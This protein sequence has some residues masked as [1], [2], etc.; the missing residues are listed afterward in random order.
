MS[1]NCDI[2]GILT[3]LDVYTNGACKECARQKGK[4]RYKANKEKIKANVVKWK[5]LN[6]EHVRELKKKYAVLNKEKIKQNQADNYKKN[7]PR[8]KARISEYREKHGERLK[9]IQ[10]ANWAINK[11]EN[12]VKSKE[13]RAKNREILRKKKLEY[14]QNIRKEA[15]FHY[16]SGSMKCASC[17]HDRWEHL[18]LDHLEGGG[19]LHRKMDKGV[20]GHAVFNWVK[21]NGYPPIFQVLCY[22]CNQIKSLRPP[23]DEKQKRCAEKLKH[24]VLSHY[25]PDL[26][27]SCGYSD[28]RALTLD[29]ID[30]GGRKHL[31][32]INVKGGAQF[33]RWVRREKYPAGLQVLC[34][35]CNCGKNTISAVSDEA[36]IPDQSSGGIP[37]QM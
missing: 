23:R 24:G 7:S 13:Y 16:S 28:I 8:I 36:C 10:R 18:C 29:H 34:Y 26:R 33:Y 31:A 6:K 19:T 5:D 27:C 4:E 30:G 3:E 11:E 32:A 35:N 37:V 14:Y 25:S 22:N 2:H 1:K 12:A 21:K 15:L 9:A 20:K 17:S